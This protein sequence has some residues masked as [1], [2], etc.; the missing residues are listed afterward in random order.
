VLRPDPSPSLKDTD[1]TKVLNEAIAAID[2]PLK[3]IANHA[4]TGE[5]HT[6]DTMAAANARAALPT[7]P[8]SH[9]ED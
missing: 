6:T 2:G 5:V 9:G 8:A 4:N 3:S 1:M 7:P